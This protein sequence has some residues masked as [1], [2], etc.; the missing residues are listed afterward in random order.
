MRLALAWAVLYSG[1]VQCVFSIAMRVLY[2]ICGMGCGLSVAWQHLTE[3][4]CP[5]ALG[6]SYVCGLAYNEDF[7]L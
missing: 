4:W 3:N 2:F 6:G 5:E 1:H 7:R